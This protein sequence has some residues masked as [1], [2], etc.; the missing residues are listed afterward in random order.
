MK[1]GRF[2]IGILLGVV[3]LYFFFRN[4]DLRQ[5]WQIIRTG[6]GWWIW[7][8]IWLC[9]FNFFVRSLRW[10]YFLKPIKW[11]GVWNAFYTTVIGFSVS[12]V[13]PARIGEI[14][15]PYLLG[16][17]ENISRSSCLATIVVERLFDTLTVLLM[18]VCY[19]LFLI[20]P[21]HLSA[22][23]RA[24]VR[25]LKETGLILFAGVALLI[26]FLYFLKRKP[27]VKLFLRKAERLLPNKIA[28]SLD[29]FLDSFIEGLSIMDSPI[30]ILK[31]AAWSA[32]LWFVIALSFWATARAYLAEF[33]LQN[34]FLIMIV[35]A[36]GIAV[37]TPGGVG[38]YHLACKI[39]LTRF[40][41]VP[42]SQATAIAVVS[43]FINFVPVLILGIFFLWHE[44]L[45]AGKITHIA[46]EASAS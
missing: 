6:S 22:E 45:S 36:I 12:A 18:L 16:S 11:V 5:I 9:L 1:K 24:S 44:G 20:D 43:H 37:P 27:G 7:A 40:F 41:G 8:A 15:R 33:P 28:S 32:F 10:R 14:V 39:G 46:E 21:E 42:E 19:L 30:L 29:H 34:V 2:I 3:L 31:I 4:M 25:Q 38:G 23:A 13:F 26:V 35:L 17:K